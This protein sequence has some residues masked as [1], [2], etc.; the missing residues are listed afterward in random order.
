[1]NL[2][3]RNLL[4]RN[5]LMRVAGTALLIAAKDIRL[6]WRNRARLFSVVIFGLVV[7]LLLSLALGPDT[8]ALQVASPGCLAVALLFSAILALSESF[9]VEGE[10]A[11]LEGL[12]LIPVEP[13]GLY[14]GKFLANALFLF[15][16]A[17]VLIP[18]TIILFVVEADLP[19]VIRLVGLWSLA[20]IGLS[21]P[22][23]LYAAMTSRLRSQDV[24]L[25]L[26]LF[27]LQVPALIALIK[28]FGFILTGDPMEQLA[29]WTSL[30]VTFDII[31][32]CLCGV[33]FPFVLEEGS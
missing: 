10:D 18:T 13:M 21:A 26:L 17:L 29:S 7:L 2:L 4:R 28:A 16:L 3:H 12:N 31:Y 27:P 24:L 1:M 14:Y 19:T 6:E 15:V 25:P 32:V 8:K 23:T 22:G 20:A 11:A 5:L 9:R 30:L 33:L